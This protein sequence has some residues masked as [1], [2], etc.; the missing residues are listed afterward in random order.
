MTVDRETASAGRPGGA[1]PPSALES[2]PPAQPRHAAEVAARI[3]AIAEPRPAPPF[4]RSLER[5]RL[6]LS[7]GRLRKPPGSTSLAGLV[8]LLLLAAA[9]TPD[10]PYDIYNVRIRSLEGG[11]AQLVL[12]TTGDVQYRDVFSRDPDRLTVDLMSARLATPA[13]E[14]LVS[15][16]GVR[17]IQLS[18]TS[19]EVVRLVVDFED[20]DNYAIYAEGNDLAIT[21]DNF[22]GD[23]A[24]Y[25]MTRNGRGGAGPA[26]GAGGAEEGAP[27]A[28]QP[29][30]AES[31]PASG[32]GAVAR[33]AAQAAAPSGQAVERQPTAAS[34]PPPADSEGLPQIDGA[35]ISVD[36][37]NADIQT[38]IRSFAEFGGVSIVAGSQVTGSITATIHDMPWDQALVS[39]MRANGYEVAYENGIIRIDSIANLRAVEQLQDLE[40]RVIPLSFV[41]SRDVVQTVDKFRSLRGAI[42][43][44]AK[45]NTIIITDVPGRVAQIVSVIDQL[46][47]QTRQVTIKA[48][49]VFVNKTDLLQFGITWRAENLRNPLTDTHLLANTQGAQTAN[50]PFLTLS[51]ATVAS[52]V[53]VGGLLNVLE[54]RQLADVQAEPQT[55]V[56]N[57]LPAEI[58]VGERT[59]IRVLDIGADQAEA[60]ATVQ[61]IETGIILDVTPHITPTGKVLMELHAERSGVAVN[62][63]AVGVTFNTQ[64]A[65][66]Q[67]LVNNGETAVIGGLTVQDISKSRTGIPLLMDIP[68]L[69]HLFSR[70]EERK[71]KRDLLIF[72][73]PYVVPTEDTRPGLGDEAGTGTGAEAGE[74]CLQGQ[75]W[76]MGDLPVLHNGARWVRFG[77]PRAESDEEL[78]VVGNFRGIT[79]Y[80]DPDTVKDEIYLPACGA[81][82]LYQAYRRETEVRGTNG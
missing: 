34:S 27:P 74:A 60:T 78:Y 14:A 70:T 22:F 65:R 73:T 17:G 36:F 4:A 10:G 35:P 66:T 69:G 75:D 67:I 9:P 38:V 71:E 29:T 49:I 59:P 28:S 43:A 16:G 24:E 12:E 40:T 80:A 72:V 68:I 18:Q 48:K 11:K 64:R 82:G 25:D 21:F 13:A 77:E 54:Q 31:A 15:R 79:I 56:L 61:L 45:T 6:A 81:E 32:V 26:P 55:T 33:P 76:Y 47:V 1:T 46:D 20:V 63:P 3:S 50:D 5:V 58:F 7:V 41:A 23:F 30:L 8:L 53:T 19:N 37:Q 39:I 52:G 44:D 57:N 51:I 42:T 2:P 62:D